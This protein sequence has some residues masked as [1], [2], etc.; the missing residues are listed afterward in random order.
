VCGSFVGVDGV[1]KRL[2]PVGVSCLQRVPATTAVA[3][4]FAATSF[5]IYEWINMVERKSSRQ[6][7]IPSRYS[8]N[9][10]SVQRPHTRADFSNFMSAA[11][12]R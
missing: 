4:P 9:S 6:P 8:P 11:S 3:P 5:K 10:A 2:H 1:D 7:A 12:S